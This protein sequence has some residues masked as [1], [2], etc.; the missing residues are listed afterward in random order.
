MDLNSHAD[1]T[2]LCDLSVHSADAVC[3]HLRAFDSG[4]RAWFPFPGKD[5][6]QSR[7]ALLGS[8]AYPYP[9]KRRRV[10]GGQTIVLGLPKRDDRVYTKIV[11]NASKTTLQASIRGK[12]NLHNI[13]PYP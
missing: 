1:A 7:C 3:W 10:D 9:G 12:V 11:L 13:Y 8:Q 4:A 5:K 6:H 2:Q